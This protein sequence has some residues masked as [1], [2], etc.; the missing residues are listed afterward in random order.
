VFAMNQK[1][2]NIQKNCRKLGKK[3]GKGSNTAQISSVLSN[4]NGR[5]SVPS[6]KNFQL[7]KLLHKK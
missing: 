4:K 5:Q 3:A 2:N 7:F 1:R 6:L